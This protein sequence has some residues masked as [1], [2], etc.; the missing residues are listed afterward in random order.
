MRKRLL[1]SLIWLCLSAAKLRGGYDVKQRG[2]ELVDTMVLRLDQ[3]SELRPLSFSEDTAPIELEDFHLILYE[4]S[5]VLPVSPSVESVEAALAK[6]LKA[7][8]N[9]HWNQNHQIASVKTSIAQQQATATRKAGETITGTQIRVMVDLLFEYQPT[10]SYDAIEASVET[11]L[12]KDLS[13]LVSNITETG[14]GDEFLE[15]I[16]TVEYRGQMPS[17]EAPTNGNTN[18]NT[19][20]NNTFTGIIT[21]EAP[22]EGFFASARF[23]V[24]ILLG[25]ALILVALLLFLIPKR[26]KDGE[27]EEL[28]PGTKDLLEP[29][30]EIGSSEG[31]GL[32]L[33]YDE[34]S[35][36]NGPNN[37][38]EYSLDQDV[39]D[40]PLTPP[41]YRKDSPKDSRSVFSGLSGGVAS[42]KTG[43]SRSVFSFLSNLGS[44]STVLASN[45]TTNQTGSP[46]NLSSKLVKSPRSDSGTPKSRVS[47]LFTFSE[48]EESD[49]DETKQ[50][51]DVE[52]T[53]EQVP[54]DE[55]DNSAKEARAKRNQ[56]AEPKAPMLIPSPLA[57]MAAGA[58]ALVKGTVHATE[59]PEAPED[60]MTSFTADDIAKDL[61]EEEIKKAKQAT[62]PDKTEPA[63]T[64]GKEINRETST[65]PCPENCGPSVC[66]TGYSGNV[67]SA[68]SDV[69]DLV[70][71]RSRNVSPRSKAGGVNTEQSQSTLAIN[72]DIAAVPN[73]DP[74]PSAKSYSA[75][76]LAAMSP[77]SDKTSKTDPGPVVIDTPSK[78]RN[79]MKLFFKSPKRAAAKRA[80]A[81]TEVT[82]AAET[83]V[84][85][86][87]EE[88]ETH[89][90]R[91]FG[92]PGLADG[93][94]AYQ[95]FT[96]EHQSPVSSQ[97]SLTFT[98]GKGKPMTP[99][100]RMK[101]EG[102]LQG[103]E[104]EWLSPSGRVRKHAKS[105]AADGTNNYQ[106]QY[107]RQ[108]ST[109]G[110]EVEDST[111][112]ESYN[113]A[114]RKR[115]MQVQTDLAATEAKPNASTPK[116]QG[117]Q[118]SSVSGLSGNSPTTKSPES[119]SS[120][121]LIDDLIWL[122]QK[123]AAPNAS[124]SK[125][126]AGDIEQIDSLSFVSGDEKIS[127]TASSDANDATN[128]NEPAE[129]IICRDCMA[130]PGKL[131]IVI[132]STKDGPAVH[133]VKKGSVLTGH[134]FAGDLIISVD[135]VDT[136][137]YSAEQVMKLMTAKN[138]YER[139]I[140]VLHIENGN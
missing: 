126:P 119:T 109:E 135:N 19:N 108:Y 85:G 136:R 17:L 82:A 112:D 121:Q 37:Y 94:G 100:E 43:D 1:F 103:T 8:L 110:L 65:S 18:T 27:V 41:S 84:S 130:P 33:Y 127:N 118:F 81:A 55:L 25:S 12:S 83:V 88:G 97:N 60:E 63:T 102:N 73:S 21:T 72:T 22:D 79:F 75:P 42:P 117:T 61:A 96:A 45:V 62:T 9:Q 128:A 49:Q 4:S 30:S 14:N 114:S 120:K 51:R 48:E 3:L 87:Q 69:E 77:K 34:N 111:I 38:S 58:M 56:K 80:V 90:R 29:L 59:Q 86:A 137:S 74:S 131:K 10:P 76:S 23:F 68:P 139:K 66:G 28:Q 122:E 46:K 57:A 124:R 52:N 6:F 70:K 2:R 15:D 64:Q 115:R 32:N 140:T 106:N 93:T 125:S 26:Q 31:V 71:K 132:H 67:T 40:I 129:V 11:I 16:H 138:K 53:E 101:F 107:M 92:S 24:P 7:E 78:S 105:T 113:G 39:E 95:T 99:A 44:K 13:N 89:D 123:I 20:N 47:S 35:P 50:T 91:A 134:L 98:R 116:S 54:F 36:S 133:T 5:G 104:E